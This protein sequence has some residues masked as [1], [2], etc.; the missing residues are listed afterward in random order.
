MARPVIKPTIMS[1]RSLL[2]AA[3]LVLAGAF[4][5]QACSKQVEGERCETANGNNDCDPGLYCVQRECCSDTIC[6]PAER[7]AATTS[8]CKGAATTP[9]DAATTDTGSTTD[10]GAATD[11]GAVTDDTGSITDTGAAIDTGSTTDAAD[12]G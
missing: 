10:T 8:E 9:T 6:C 1:F 2:S 4:V 3:A 5:F 11:T 12:A 7:S